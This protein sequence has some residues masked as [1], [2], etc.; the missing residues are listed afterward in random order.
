MG[1]YGCFGACLIPVGHLC[2][3]QGQMLTLFCSLCP[4]S[5]VVTLFPTLNRSTLKKKK[6]SR[7]N[8]VNIPNLSIPSDAWTLLPGLEIH[9][10][11]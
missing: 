1:R 4:E 8:R 5:A 2:L 10:Q 7:S 9:R 11:L 3:D 6:E